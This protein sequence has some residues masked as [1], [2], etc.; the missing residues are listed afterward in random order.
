MSDAIRAEILAHAA[1]GSLLN[2][3]F[4]D[5]GSRS[6]DDGDPTIAMLGDLHNG[7]EI[8]LLN[9]VTRESIQ[10]F[11]G[12]VF[13]GGQQVYR[14]LIS[15]LQAPAEALLNVVQV[16][17]EAAGQDMAAGMPV[18]E[19]SKW[20]GSE[21]SR[22]KELLALVD[23]KVPHA[24]RFLTIAIKQGVAVDRP[25]FLDRA[26]GFLTG[27]SETER[28]AAIN[29]LGQ[30]PCQS[31]AEWDRFVAAFSDL[32]TAE[33]TIRA[34]LITAVARRLK[35]APPG[36]RDQLTELAVAALEQRGDHTLD[37]AARTLAFDPEHLPDELIDALLEALLAIK[38]ANKGTVEMLDLALMKLVQ[39]GH[40]ER[41]RHY[42][43]HILRREED[44]IELEE[45]DS[46]S[47]TLRNADGQVLEDW[48][49]AWL[50]DGDY[51]LCGAM[52]DA[53]F[54]AGSDEFDF[55]IDFAR[56][57]LTDADYPYL[58]RKA[59]A[60]FFLKQSVMA[61]LI[62]SLL[63]S[64]PAEAADAIVELLVDPI[65]INYSGIADDYLK[66][67]SED[68]TDPAHTAVQRALAGQEAYL[69]GLSSIG[70]VPELHPSERE[71]QLELQR[72]S[73]SMSEA[74]RAARK[75]SIFA[76]IA[77][78]S[79]ILYG[80]RAVSW[81]RDHTDEPR[82]IETPMGSIS[83]SFE[84][85]RVEIVDPMGLQMMLLHF[86]GEDRTK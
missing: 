42:L 65:L 77:T 67:I 33:D 51:D 61:S 7:G 70:I 23:R 74:W 28:Q 49:V 26:Y 13:W 79:L 58:A 83:H 12:Q 81:F 41:A 47:Y 52:N 78:E 53:L 40:A 56:F 75:K 36:R 46:L 4:H 32:V 45:L 71:R 39:N 1:N 66:P 64:A 10:A 30:I 19:F 85:P 57:V 60:T 11:E 15:R 76:E 48:V 86:R 80:I 62:V 35:D 54:G 82:R 21:P 22:P 24:D 69:D 72:H 38:G 73:D 2:A 50:L 6:H 37:T 29:A 84:M 55:G 8:D 63:R 44:R 16:L 68:D 43:E 14:A 59:I 34:P 5:Y 17:I 25:Y 27:G 31:D 20:C 3:I 18:E 9:I